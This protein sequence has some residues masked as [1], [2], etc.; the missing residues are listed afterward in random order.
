MKY[1][2]APFVLSGPFHEFRLV[3][4]ARSSLGFCFDKK[5]F[6]FTALSTELFIANLLYLFFKENPTINGELSH[7]FRSL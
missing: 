2:A 6:H 3:D 7:F 4:P 5:V 1:I